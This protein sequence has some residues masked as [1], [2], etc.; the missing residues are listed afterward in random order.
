[1]RKETTI[2]FRTTEE[3]RDQLDAEA[4]ETNRSLSSTLEIILGGFLDKGNHPVGIQEKR[5]FTRKAVTIPA[6]M[7]CGDSRKR[8]QATICNIS[9]GGFLLRCRPDSI[10]EFHGMN[11]TPHVE[12][13]FNLPKDGEVTVKSKIERIVPAKDGVLLGATLVNSDFTSM[14]RLQNFLV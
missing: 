8:H 12:V 11:T 10:S 7:W 13:T 2:C 1:M 4:R 14:V 3:I 6:Q 5:R 9:L